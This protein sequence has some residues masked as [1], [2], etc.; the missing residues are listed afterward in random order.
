MWLP[1]IVS[2]AQHEGYEVRPIAKLSCSS[3]AWAGAGSN[4]GCRAWYKWAVAQVRAIHPSLLILATHYSDVSD[5]PD[6][7]AQN[8]TNLGN[9]YSS[10]HSSTQELVVL[11]DAPGQSGGNEPIDCL[12]RSHAT[13]MSCSS[14]ETQTQL[15]TDAS[16]S[17][18]AADFG[19]F[20]DTT[21]WFCDNLSCP[22]VVGHTV[23]YTDTN[24]MTTTYAQQLAPLFEVTLHRLILDGAASTRHRPH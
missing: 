4:S 19:A 18:E 12:Q 9:F 7:S 13:M 16:V 22:M 5:S 10:V 1:D 17:S 21:P 3:V 6:L 15:S 23:V 8:L 14:T 2:F 24:H 20:L 11:G